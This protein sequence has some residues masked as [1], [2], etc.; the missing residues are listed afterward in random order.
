MKDAPRHDDISTNATPHPHVHWHTRS[1]RHRLSQDA[2]PP[3]FGCTGFI[4]VQPDNPLNQG[5]ERQAAQ[6]HKKKQRSYI[7]QKKEERKSTVRRFVGAS[8]LIRSSNG[9]QR[10]VV[11]RLR[12]WLPRACIRRAHHSCNSRQPTSQT[13]TITKDKRPEGMQTG[14][15]QSTDTRYP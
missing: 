5:R 10:N 8:L 13:T 4:P 14:R 15:R 7:L 11:S 9:K 1:R 12:S 6:H 2:R 3:P